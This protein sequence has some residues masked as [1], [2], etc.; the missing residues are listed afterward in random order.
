VR[1]LALRLERVGSKRADAALIPRG[2]DVLLG[3]LVVLP[4][5]VLAAVRGF[6]GLYGQDA[7][8]YFDYAIGPLREAIL[9]LQRPDSAFFWPPGYPLLVALTSLAVGPTPLA[10]QLVSL[11]MGG[12]VPI[13]T[14]LLARELLPDSEPILPL[15]AGALV[16]LSGQLWQSSMVVMADTT[17]LALATV[18]A[19]ALAR[20][21]REPRLTWLVLA[22]VAVAFAILTRWAYALAAI[23][24]GLYALVSTRRR[25]HILIAAAVGLAVLGPVLGPSVIAIL[26]GSAPGTQTQAS[27]AGNLQVYSWSPLNAFLREF[28]TADGVLRYTLPNGLY[29]AVAPANPA[30]LGPLLAPWIALGAW[31]AARTWPRSGLLVIVGWALIVYA[32]HAGA[33]WQNFRFTLAYLPPLAILVAVGLV[34]AWRRVEHRLD[35]AVV[36]VALLGL[37]SMALS[38]A[39]L[40]QG[41][42]DRKDVDLGMVRWVEAE[43]EPGARLLTFGPTLT[44]KHYSRLPTLEIFELSP[45]Q[46]PALLSSNQPSYVLV[47]EVNVQDQWRDRAPAQVFQ[48]LRDGPGLAPR[49]QFGSFSLFRIGGV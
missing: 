8:A 38:G 14:A 19:W 43:A 28:T 39:R 10:G 46:L 7:F 16:G 47:D 1:L 45:S 5:G 21:S 12:L 22:A 23:P 15:L 4:G 24:F 44:F 20:H 40:V 13:F 25:S 6:D 37:A 30:L 31:V 33:P 32:F 36:V 41:F 26:Q 18:A 48:W 17:G 11:V 35:R 2:A 29:Y 27:F 42:I 49:G 34:W 9:Q 3:L